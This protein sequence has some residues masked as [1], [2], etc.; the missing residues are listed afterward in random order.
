MD[1][2]TSEGYGTFIVS[3]LLQDKWNACPKLWS[4][5]TRTLKPFFIKLL[6]DAIG[7]DDRDQICKAH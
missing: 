6:D 5:Y 2:G 7:K 1:R 4:I 3:N